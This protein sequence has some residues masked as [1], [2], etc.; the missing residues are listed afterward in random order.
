MWRL[1]LGDWLQEEKHGNRFCSNSNATKIHDADKVNFPFH[2][3]ES[4]SQRK[5]VSRITRYGFPTTN[6]IQFPISRLPSWF[7][8]IGRKRFQL[9]LCNTSDSLE[10]LY[11]PNQYALCLIY[12]L[13]M[14]FKATEQ[15]FRNEK[16]NLTRLGL[17]IMYTSRRWHRRYIPTCWHTKC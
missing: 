12:P 10:C 5:P 15:C 2:V 6:T 11:F 13:V 1:N 17:E 3:T 7:W 4:G 16:Q 9:K 14:I 8:C